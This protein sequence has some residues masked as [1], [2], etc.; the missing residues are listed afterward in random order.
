MLNDKFRFQVQAL[1][2]SRLYTQRLNLGGQSKPLLLKKIY[3]NVPSSGYTQ[4]GLI[5][6]IFAFYG[7]VTF[8]LYAF[9]IQVLPILFTGFV[10]GRR[11]KNITLLRP[12]FSS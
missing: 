9:L 7:V 4:N 3:F 5:N 8:C 6:K 11:Y 10:L 1:A 2:P 12:L